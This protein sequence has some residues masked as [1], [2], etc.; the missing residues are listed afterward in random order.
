MALSQKAS[1]TDN[2]Q[3]EKKKNVG[4]TMF[5]ILHE[6]YG[7]ETWFNDQHFVSRSSY[8]TF[9]FHKDLHTLFQECLLDLM[10]FDQVA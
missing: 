4:S 7:S 8:L 9:E 10:P 5:P 6:I 1:R 3:K 2:T